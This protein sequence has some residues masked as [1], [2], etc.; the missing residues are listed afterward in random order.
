LA[1]WRAENMRMTT[2]S[3]PGKECLEVRRFFLRLL[4]NCLEKSSKNYREYLYGNPDIP[5]H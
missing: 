3:F 1:Q 4:E 5:N 2:A